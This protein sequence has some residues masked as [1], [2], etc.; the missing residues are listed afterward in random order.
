MTD[1]RLNGFSAE[2]LEGK[3]RRMRGEGVL[4]P[5]SSS[6]ATCVT[7]GGRVRGRGGGGRLV[8]TCGGDVEGLCDVDCVLG[9]VT[10][11]SE[12]EGRTASRRGTVSP[13]RRSEVVLCGVL[14]D[15]PECHV[16]SDREPLATDSLPSEVA[17]DTE[18]TE[19][20]RSRP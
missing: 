14:I 13:V 9:S 5:D 4:I 11:A 8:M 17:D 6:D 7:I 3:L 16:E 20:L 18:S 2:A 1:W 10:W 12:V 19:R 15:V